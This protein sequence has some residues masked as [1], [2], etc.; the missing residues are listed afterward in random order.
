MKDDDDDAEDLI[1]LLV[2]APVMF[3]CFLGIC[4]KLGVL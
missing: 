2:F 3:I 1:T 4:A